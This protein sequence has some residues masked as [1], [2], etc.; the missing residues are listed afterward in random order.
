M[1]NFAQ[2]TTGSNGLRLVAGFDTSGMR[3][4]ET[5]KRIDVWAIETSKRDVHYWKNVKGKKTK[6]TNPNP[7]LGDLSDTRFQI[8]ANHAIHDGVLLTEPVELEVGSRVIRLKVNGKTYLLSG[9]RVYK[10]QGTN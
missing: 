1:G 10:R 5:G 4:S 8:L 3:T 9:G 2:A 7:R 6:M